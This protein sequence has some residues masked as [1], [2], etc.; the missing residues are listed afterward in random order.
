LTRLPAPGIAGRKGVGPAAAGS[1]A[2]PAP[3]L[4]RPRFE[5][6]GEYDYLAELDYAFDLIDRQSSGNLAAF[7]ADPLPAAVGLRVL[8]VVTV[9]EDE[10]DLGLELLGQ[11]IE[12]SL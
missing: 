12:R 1:F 3:F 7:I 4:Y 9:S 8:D 6:N 2:I 11:A 5:R 10:I